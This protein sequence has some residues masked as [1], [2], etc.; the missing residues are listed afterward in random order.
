MRATIE[1]LPEYLCFDRSN[2]AGVLPARDGPPHLLHTSTTARAYLNV[3]LELV[4]PWRRTPTIA[5]KRQGISPAPVHQFQDEDGGSGGWSWSWSG[6]RGTRPQREIVAIYGLQ[7]LAYRPLQN[8]AYRPPTLR[9]WRTEHN[10]VIAFSYAHLQRSA[11]HQAPP[12]PP[13]SASQCAQR[14]MMDDA[15]D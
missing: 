2:S 15:E 11:Q 10:T 9:R 14:D 4:F 3:I 13:G 12:I 5:T 1:T 7:S 8:L 6:R